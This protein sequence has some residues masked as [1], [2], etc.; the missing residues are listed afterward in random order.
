MGIIKGELDVFLQVIVHFMWIQTG[1]QRP[2]R[3]VNAL[4]EIY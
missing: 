1:M 3:F 2:V 4:Q